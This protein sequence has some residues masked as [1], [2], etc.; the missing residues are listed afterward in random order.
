MI[1]GSGFGHLLYLGL[2]WDVGGRIQL[3]KA[4]FE[5]SGCA[6]ML[7]LLLSAR[8]HIR[9]KGLV[10]EA[11]CDTTAVPAAPQG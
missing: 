5:I 8:L 9:W 7:V 1:T 11:L 4:P 2:S 10:L 6:I 3:H